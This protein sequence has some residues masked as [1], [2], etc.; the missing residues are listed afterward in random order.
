MNE[1]AEET[2][3]PAQQR[4]ERQSLEIEHK[5]A[6]ERAMS[7]KLLHDV[8]LA[9]EPSLDM[10][11]LTGDEVTSTSESASSGR[12]NWDELVEQLLDDDESG[13]PVFKED[14]SFGSSNSDA[15]LER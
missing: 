12:T 13:D 2:T 3:P 9:E 5:D 7:L 15:L 6:L 1:R 11:P 8:A 10:G 4:M 14:P